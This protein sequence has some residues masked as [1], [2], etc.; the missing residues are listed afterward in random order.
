M[1]SA[2]PLVKAKPAPAQGVK[3]AAEE[4]TGDL[5][6]R[7]TAEPAA[8]PAAAPPAESPTEQAPPQDLPSAILTR[9]K[10]VAMDNIK[11]LV[12]ETYKRNNIEITEKEVSDIASLSC[13]MAATDIAEV[14]SPKR[15]TALAHQY[16]LR[17][18]FAVD[19]CETKA[20]G[21][22]WNLNKPADVE[23]LFK[24][25]D[26]DE[27]LLITGSPPCHLFSKLQAISWNKIPPEIRE[28]RMTEALHHLHTSCDEYEKQIQEGRYFL[29]EAPWGAT[30]WKDERVERISQRDDV[31]VVRG[32]MCKWGMTAADRRGLQGTGY[33]RKETGWMTNHPGLAELLETECTNKTGEAP[34]HRHVHLIGGIA[35]QAAKYPP[36]LVRAVPQERMRGTRRIESGRCVQCRTSPRDSNC[37]SRLG[38]TIHRRCEWRHF[39]GRRSKKSESSG[40]GLLAQT[41]SVPSC[42]YLR[43]L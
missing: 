35:Q 26:Q 11:A 33:V 21:E 22:H 30:S 9:F 37:G 28:K 14:Y 36:Q 1:A 2:P 25:I 38:R 20:H 18:G 12:E 32:P 15:F 6:E 4:G 5:E 13:E 40:N 10:E 39:A 27:P 41:A 7:T 19:L 29:H 23:E 31:Y 3:R 34:C 43:M 17:P 16:K 8:A 24:L 42:A